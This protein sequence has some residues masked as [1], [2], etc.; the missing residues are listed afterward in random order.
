[1]LL[2]INIFTAL[3]ATT[4]SAAV[5]RAEASMKTARLIRVMATLAPMPSAAVSRLHARGEAAD[6]CGLRGRT[7][8]ATTLRT[9]VSIRNGKKIVIP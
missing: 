4:A 3:T 5:A 2:F 9:G 8:D 7:A 6:A 1:M